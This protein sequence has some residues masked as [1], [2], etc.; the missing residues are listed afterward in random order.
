MVL[1]CPWV[2]N[3]I[4]AGNH[5]YFILFLATAQAALGSYI[6]TTVL[7]L[8]TNRITPLHPVQ[9]LF[10]IPLLI[11]AALM[12]L[13]VLALLGSQLRL[14]AAGV[15]TNERM[16]GWRYEWMVGGVRGGSLYDEG[17]SLGNCAVFWRLKDAR[18]VVEEVD[19][20]EG[21]RAAA[22]GGGGGA[23]AG[24]GHGHAHAG[25]GG[26]GGHGGHG[27]RGGHGHSHAGGG[28]HG[29]SH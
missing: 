1:D 12:T 20:S 15:T 18:K 10:A 11:H 24:G 2:N 22:G 6:A 13:Y 17:N 26:G 3:C 14:V 16:N 27:G 9:W 29:H 8:Q 4:G 21:G 23:G 5:L 28:H 25:G 19:V 7:Y